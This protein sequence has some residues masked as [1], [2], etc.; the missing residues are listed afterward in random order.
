MQALERRLG[1]GAAATINILTMIGVGPF[2]TIPLLLQT[3]Q[4]PQAMLGWVLGAAIAIADGLVWAELGAAMPHSG[5]GYHYVLQAY[6]PH[7]P[8]R[9]VSFL[10]L[11]SIV[12][13]SPLLFSSG[14][15]GF[16]QYAAYLHP[17]MTP[18]QA[19]LL[20][21]GVCAVSTWL[22]YRRIDRVGRWGIA[23]AL[24]VLLA[25]TWIVGEGVL[26][27][28]W[29]QISPP[30]GAFHLSGG[31][32]YGLGGATLY[33]MYD[34]AGYNT[35]CFV[36]GEVVRPEATIPRSVVIAIAVVGAFYL[37]MNFA[38]VGVMPWREAAQSKFV[39]S[40]F[41]GRLHGHRA[42]S[43]MTMLIL[44]TTLASLFGGMLGVSRIPYAAAVDGRFFRPFARVHATGRFPS[45]SVLFIGIASAACCLLDLEVAIKAFTVTSIILGSLT[46]VVAPTL[47]RSAR[48]D[49]RLPFRMWLY[50]LPSLIALAGWTYIVA[51]NGAAYIAIGLGLLGVGIAAYLWR[52][53][54]AAEWPYACR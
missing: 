53:R 48:P 17:A 37:S 43:F 9:L 16:S 45:F 47:L 25:A 36:G 22:I 34:Y 23:F 8:G 38:I 27:A 24:P 33:A 11:W 4:G 52:A 54:K 13:S 26:N 39:A 28:R 3:M 41:I 15:I 30:A 35:V 5:G 21:M 12:I 29:D 18:W 20:A 50:P 40:D 10:Y 49:I 6:E 42:A 2:L 32:W 31:F 1:L 51:T 7:G 14:A 44:A 46:V 19:K